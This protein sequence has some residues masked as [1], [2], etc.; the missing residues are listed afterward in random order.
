MSTW[1]GFK[2]RTHGVLGGWIM[3]HI[4]VVAFGFATAPAFWIPL[5]VTQA[6]ISPLINTSNQSIWQAKVAPDI[7]GRVFSARRLIAWFTQPIAPLI[8]GLLAD[9]WFEPSMTSGTTSL[10]SIFSG[11]VGTGP[12]SGMALLF[13][14]AGMGPILVGLTGYFIQPIRDAETILPDHDTLLKAEPA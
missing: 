1:G 13:I 5:A 2:K 6:I 10:A 9:K 4:F 3:S 8:A 12:G 14:F 11:W 7:Q